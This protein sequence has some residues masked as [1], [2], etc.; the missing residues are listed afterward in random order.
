MIQ[1]KV[2]EQAVS[3]VQGYN[4][5]RYV[6][7][8][9]RKIL[10][11]AFYYNKVNGVQTHRPVTLS[12]R[13]GQLLMLLSDGYNHTYE[14]ICEFLWKLEVVTYKKTKGKTKIIDRKTAMSR[15]RTVASRLE[16]RIRTFE[17]HLKHR[18]GIGIKLVGKE[19]IW[20]E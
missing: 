2:K 1:Q 7:D 3:E 15:I 5:M 4:V 13:E 11:D 8:T 19:E 16:K 9:K 17:T 6:Y 18:W 10:R 12:K 20:L 14:E